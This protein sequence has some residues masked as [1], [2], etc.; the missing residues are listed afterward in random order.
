MGEL[1]HSYNAFYVTA[2]PCLCHSFPMSMSQFSHVY[3]LK[4]MF[5]EPD[6]LIMSRVE[7]T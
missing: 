3:G 7:L 1:T 5:S 4:F 6:F 2:F